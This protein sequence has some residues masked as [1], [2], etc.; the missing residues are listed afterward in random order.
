MADIFHHFPIA[1]SAARVFDAIATP[2]GLDAWWTKTATGRPD[3]G[4]E[5]ELWFGP[6]SDWR[7]TVSRAVEGREFELTLTRADDDWRGT[8]VGFALDEQDGRTQ[9]RFHHTGWP[10]AND[11]FR[12]STFCWAMYLRLLKRYVEN[13]EVVPYDDRLDV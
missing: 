6:G 13:G 8:K 9:V 1:A 10:S 3:E 12:T 7:A 5:Y 11:H 2:E 4:E